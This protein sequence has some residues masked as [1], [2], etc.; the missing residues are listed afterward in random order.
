M[1]KLALAAVAVGAISAA[2]VA[3][4]QARSSANGRQSDIDRF[5]VAPATAAAGKVEAGTMVRHRR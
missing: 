2:T 3:P 5:V 4:A 1:R